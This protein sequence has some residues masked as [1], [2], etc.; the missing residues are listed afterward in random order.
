MSRSEELV[1][2]VKA[3]LDEELASTRPTTEGGFVDAILD[4]GID[5][6]LLIIKLLDAAPVDE[7]RIILML[8]DDNLKTWAENKGYISTDASIDDFME[9]QVPKAIRDWVLE[10]IGDRV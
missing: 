6:T 4:S 7:E 3:L 8:D 2:K 10:W 1:N 9:L 5:V